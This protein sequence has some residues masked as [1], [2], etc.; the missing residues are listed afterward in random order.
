MSQVYLLLRNIKSFSETVSTA[1]T[2]M[3]AIYTL[4][5]QTLDRLIKRFFLV[6]ESNQN[7]KHKYI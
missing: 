7:D 6:G 5:K 4:N 3:F 1:A 2:V